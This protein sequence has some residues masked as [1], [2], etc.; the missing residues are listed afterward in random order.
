MRSHYSHNHSYLKASFNVITKLKG[1]RISHCLKHTCLKKVMKRLTLCGSTEWV[2]QGAYKNNKGTIFL[3]M[4]WA[5]D[6][7]RRLLNDSWKI[8]VYFSSFWEKNNTQLILFP[9]KLS[10]WQNTN[11]VRTNQ[12]TWSYLKTMSP[13]SN[14][15]LPHSNELLPHSN[16]L[17]QWIQTCSKLYI[18]KTPLAK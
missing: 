8:N 12:N 16:E 17:L 14:E 4:A 2:Q 9:W 6:V 3:S 11:Q 18:L 10:I 7:I 1:E 15:L 5:S 13:H